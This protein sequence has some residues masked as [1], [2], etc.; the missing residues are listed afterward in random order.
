M[1]KA[2][3]RKTSP[4]SAK[5][6]FDLISGLPD[7]TP[8]L[9]HHLCEMF[10]TIGGGDMTTEEFLDSEQEALSARIDGITTTLPPFYMPHPI[11]DQPSKW[12]EEAGFGLWLRGMDFQ[13]WLV[14]KEWLR[15]AAT[16][17]TEFC[18]IEGRSVPPEVVAGM[19]WRVL[20]GHLPF[21]ILLGEIGV[22]RNSVNCIDMFLEMSGSVRTRKDATKLLCEMSSRGW[23]PGDMAVYLRDR[24]HHVENC[25]SIFNGP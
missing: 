15:Q 7:D 19:E 1:S 21:G 25:R 11:E 9:F 3:E 14:P 12:F 24:I 18:S 8:V 5:G 17:K 10:R 20:F 22:Y 6:G 13:L 16:W 2:K 23:G 4:T